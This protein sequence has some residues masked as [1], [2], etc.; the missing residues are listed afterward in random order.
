MTRPRKPTTL[1]AKLAAACDKVKTVPK[2]GVNS[3]YQGGYVKAADVYTAL[4]HELLSR[5]VMLV[6]N[7]LELAQERIQTN[8]GATITEAVLKVEYV[9]FD[10]I[11]EPMRFSA[12]GV[13]RDDEEKGVYKAKTGAEKYFLIGLGMLPAEDS[14]PEFESDMPS[15][16]VDEPIAGTTKKAKPVRKKEQHAVRTFEVAGFQKAC[17]ETSKSKAEISAYLSKEWG[18]ATIAQLQRKNFKVA[19][20]WAQT[21][22]DSG[23]R[24]EASGSAEHSVTEEGAESQTQPTATTPPEMSTEAAREQLCAALVSQGAYLEPNKKPQLVVREMD[25]EIEPEFQLRSY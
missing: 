19:L 17:E 11:A 24:A 23:G 25:R 9:I 20:R 12:F 10:G 14:D 18:I 13:G 6:P 5:G 7:E 22:K 8:G 16:V 1:A 3:K 4:R 15:E 21:K 2:N